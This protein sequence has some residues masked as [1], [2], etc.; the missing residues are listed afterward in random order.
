MAG[1]QFVGIESVVE[2]YANSKR[3]A[4]AVCSGKQVNGSGEGAEELEKFLTMLSE[5]GIDPT[6]TLKVYD[7]PADTINE[8][9][10]CSQSFNFRFAPKPARQMS[11]APQL[12]PNP[13]T[14]TV[15]DRIKQKIYGRMEGRIDRI[16][17]RVLDED[18]EGDEP[19]TGFDKVIGFIS[20]PENLQLILGALQLI[21]GSLS[22]NQPAGAAMPLPVASP[23]YTP[24]PSIMNGVTK[25]D[26]MAEDMQER[27]VKV[28]DELEKADPRIIDHLEMLARLAKKNPALFKMLLMQLEAM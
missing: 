11:G 8:K 20:K 24:A 10:V 18:D 14:G 3:D 28:F 12:V 13:M 22:G 9:T 16:I 23:I 25:Q 21:K 15:E 4:W 27:I 1:L 17:D 26:V 19:E 5:Y 7:C 6:Y 2:A